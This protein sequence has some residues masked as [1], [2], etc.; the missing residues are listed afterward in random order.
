MTATAVQPT[1]SA[2]ILE[3]LL[4]E[5]GNDRRRETLARLKEACDALAGRRHP[6]KLAD[7]QKA[8]EGKHGKE[9]GPKAQS[10]SNERSRPL[11]MYHYV[12]ARERERLAEAAPQPIRRTRGGDA[13]AAMIDRIDDMDTRSA[14]YDLQD[15]CLLA[16]KALE[17]A[18]ALFKALRPGA[19]LDRLL[20]GQEAAVAALP[21]AALAEEQV[22][23][24]GRLL[25]IL[26]DDAKLATVGLS[27]DGR[28]V[29]RKA[30]TRDELIDPV[31]LDL[32][33]ALLASLGGR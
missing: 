1:T 20:G 27:Y 33:A 15:R 21:T 23:A 5:A 11:G 30:G 24:L 18:K 32:C 7:I 22:A 29:R 9:A 12:E 8:V 17:R 14:V 2:M 4:A 3:N 26:T 10:I 25:A 28:R 31:T 19:D 6:L 13:L 16:E